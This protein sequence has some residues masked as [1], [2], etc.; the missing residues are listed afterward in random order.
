MELNFEVR[1]IN[2]Y[3]FDEDVLIEEQVIMLKI[4]Y[5]CMIK[6][7]VWKGVQGFYLFVINGIDFNIL[8]I[9]MGI[10]LLVFLVVGEKYRNVVL[11]VV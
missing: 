7:C 3:I 1:F 6:L 2:K 4:V 9:M 8:F 5:N 10:Y 11:V